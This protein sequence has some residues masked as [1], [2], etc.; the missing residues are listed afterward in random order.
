MVWYLPHKLSVTEDGLEAE[1]GITINIFCG[2][3]ISITLHVLMK[4]FRKENNILVL[5]YKILDVMKNLGYL[6]SSTKIKIHNLHFIHFF[7][8][9]CWYSLYL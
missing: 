9:A 5:E 3:G 2:I 8:Y 4:K 7:T 6:L 1:T